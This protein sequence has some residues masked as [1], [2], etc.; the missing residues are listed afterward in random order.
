MKTVR[1]HITEIMNQRFG[2]L[3]KIIFLV[4]QQGVP[5]DSYGIHAAS[6]QVE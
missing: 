4:K 2:K 3:N 5:G 1:P 6:V